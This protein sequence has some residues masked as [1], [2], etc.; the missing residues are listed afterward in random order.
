MFEQTNKW[1]LYF[2]SFVAVLYKNIYTKRIRR[3][4]NAVFPWRCLL[5]RGNYPNPHGPCED[6]SSPCLQQRAGQQ[7]QLSSESWPPRLQNCCKPVGGFFKQELPRSGHLSR[8]QFLL[9]FS[10]AIQRWTYLCALEHCTSAERKP[11]MHTSEVLSKWE[12][13]RRSFVF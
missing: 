5:S 1:W 3:T 2:S 12:G 8:I 6:V 11:E 13:C 9:C 4:E 10:S 7:P